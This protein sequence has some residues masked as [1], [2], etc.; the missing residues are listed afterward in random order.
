[1]ADKSPDAFRTISEVSEW[2]DTPA[3]V[4]RFW[5]S[6]FPQIK[7]VKRAG[8]RRYYRP[9]DMML[10]GGIKKLLHFDEQPIK[11][12]KKL[13]KE[14]GVKHVMALSP[15]LD[16]PIQS[17]EREEK[18]Q[19]TAEIDK[20]VQDAE[21]KSAQAAPKVSVKVVKKA[22]PAEPEAVTEE[23]PEAERSEPVAHADATEDSQALED[24]ER[25]S[26]DL[27]DSAPMVLRS[28]RAYEA[29]QVSEISALYSKLIAVR[30]RLQASG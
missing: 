21:D 7:P 17:P 27:I 10:L 25:E 29:D 2:L 16:T 11:A 20:I 12:V 3:Y 14:E 9:E 18:A 28:A 15:D 8:G 30:D 23:A 26:P 22:K 19:A 13:L 4:L 24:W 5:E 1:M 6:R